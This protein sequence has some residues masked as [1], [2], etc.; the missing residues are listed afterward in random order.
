M[1]EI[2]KA[3]WNSLEHITSAQSD[4]CAAHPQQTCQ[5][6]TATDISGTKHNS[7]IFGFLA[8]HLDTAGSSFSVC[9]EDQN[10]QLACV[11][12][13][14]RTEPPLEK[15]SLCLRMND[16]SQQISLVTAGKHN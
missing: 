14:R 3:V 9:H 8:L 6:L 13:D 1:V 16:G 4:L 5:Q 2:W 11:C 12:S 7:Q 10:H 15:P